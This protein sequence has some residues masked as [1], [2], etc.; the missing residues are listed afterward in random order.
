MFSIPMLLRLAPYI[1]IALLIGGLLWY[2]GEAI[3]AAAT[4][5]A[6]ELQLVEVKAANEAQAKAIDRITAQRAADDA[7]LVQLTTT[8][9]DLR[10]KADET[11]ASI[12]EL[13]RTNE[14]VKTYLSNPVPGD[15]KRLLNRPDARK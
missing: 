2:R 11:Q 12:T 10:T 4:L 8:L 9:T 14:E 15:L 1:V 6:K 5:K 13:E 7:V 3:D